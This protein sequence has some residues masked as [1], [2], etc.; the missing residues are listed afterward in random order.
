MAL[1]SQSAYFSLH[2]DADQPFRRDEG[3][4]CWQGCRKGSR[5]ASTSASPVLETETGQAE[6]GPLLAILLV[7][8]TIA[9]GSITDR[10][11]YTPTSQVD[12]GLSR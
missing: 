5:S 11:L 1:L 9:T 4:Q 7:G 8:R 3:L 10:R 2:G 6:A 12:S